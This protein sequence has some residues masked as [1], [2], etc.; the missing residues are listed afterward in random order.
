M[1]CT[2]FLRDVCCNPLYFLLMGCGS[3]IPGK[4]AVQPLVEKIRVLLHDKLG[5]P[6]GES[7]L[8]PLQHSIRSVIIP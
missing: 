2:F 1:I 8:L 3:P 6:W 5:F 7:H 4:V